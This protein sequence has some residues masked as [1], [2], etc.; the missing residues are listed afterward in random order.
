MNL[1]MKIAPFILAGLITFVAAS[2]PAQPASLRAEP[3]QPSPEGG[4]SK[5]DLD[6]PGG[7]PRELVKDIQKAL[8]KPLNAIIPE[9]YMDTMLPALKMKGVDV[10]QLFQALQS[11][12]SKQIAYVTSA[13]YSSSGRSST[14][15]YQYYT[16]SCGFKTVPGRPITDDTIWWFYVDRPSLPE[17]SSLMNSRVCRFYAL[18]PYLERHLTVDDITTAI[19]TGWKMLGEGTPAN[20]SFH[21]DT[22]LLIAVGEPSALEIIDAVLKALDEPKQGAPAAGQSKPAAAPK[23]AENRPSSQR[24]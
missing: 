24:Q 23:P 4:L 2:A 14:R 9:E 18:G 22:K 1:F 10:A 19:E 7:I 6:F 21:K 8:G 11:A 3:G 20:I 5:F 15:S 13:N 16:T 17:G 12:T